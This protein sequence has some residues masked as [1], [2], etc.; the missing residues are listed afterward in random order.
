MQIPTVK[1]TRG[2]E[3]AIVNEADLAR[4][5]AD[6]WKTAEKAPATAPAA[7]TAAKAKGKGR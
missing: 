4:W 7:K 2:G 1:V 5:T 3:T 6:G